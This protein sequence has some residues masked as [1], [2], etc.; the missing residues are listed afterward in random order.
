MSLGNSRVNTQKVFPFSVKLFRSLAEIPHWPQACLMVL[1]ILIVSWLAAC[2][3]WGKALC[4]LFLLFCCAPLLQQTSEATPHQ[5]G[6]LYQQKAFSSTSRKLV[7]HVLCLL[8]P[9]I[10]MR[11]FQQAQLLPIEEVLFLLC[12]WV[13][14]HRIFCGE[15]CWRGYV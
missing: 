3:F 11:K 12:S 2:V 4:F 6:R 9:A 15:R 14:G 10:S 5:M 1:Q 13:G 7:R 8:S